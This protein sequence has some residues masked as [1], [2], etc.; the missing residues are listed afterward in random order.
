MHILW[1]M[2]SFYK[3]ISLISR[4][5]LKLMYFPSP[6]WAHLDL[7]SIFIFANSS[8]ILHSIWPI[9]RFQRAYHSYS[10]I[11][12]ACCTP[13]PPFPLRR[14]L[15][16]NLYYF[17]SLDWLLPRWP[18]AYTQYLPTP[19]L[20]PPVWLNVRRSNNHI[21]TLE[22]CYSSRTFQYTRALVI[23]FAV[24]DVTSANHCYSSRASAYN[25]PPS[26]AS[27]PAS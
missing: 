27:M 20:L 19:V 7:L 24:I 17:L 22:S 1:N 2:T 10:A 8:H 9:F 12:A 18:D 25:L 6:F 11:S 4:L 13:D 3:C 15:L 16:I 21:W 14:P 26:V 23:T 5:C